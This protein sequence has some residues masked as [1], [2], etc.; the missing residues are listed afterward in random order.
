MK[1]LIKNGILN[2]DEEERIYEYNKRGATF[3]FF[4][5]FMGFSEHKKS[6]DGPPEEC[7]NL[8]KIL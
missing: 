4:P 6:P 2:M 8:Y 3:W 1:I 7:K 5:L